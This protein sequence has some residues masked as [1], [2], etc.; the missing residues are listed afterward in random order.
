MS[1]HQEL[2]AAQILE[3][4]GDLMS[5]TPIVLY[6][7]NN[8]VRHVKDVHDM[9]VLDETGEVNQEAVDEALRHYHA[10]V[11]RGEVLPGDNLDATDMSNQN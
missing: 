1:K 10:W 7:W 3:V 11:F 9:D 8:A 6:R 4:Y 2:V 5:A